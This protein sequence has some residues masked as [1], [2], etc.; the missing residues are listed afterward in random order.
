[1]AAADVIVLASARR[2]CM[3]YLSKAKWQERHFGRLVYNPTT[4]GL[5]LKESPLVSVESVVLSVD[6]APQVLVEG[7]DYRVDFIRSALV[8][9]APVT[10]CFH[11]L[12]IRYTAG[13]AP[14]PEDLQ[15][16]LDAA[17]QA[18]AAAATAAPAGVQS[19]DIPDVGGVRFADPSAY[20]SSLVPALAPFESVLN[21]YRDTSRYFPEASLRECVLVPEV[22]PLGVPQ[23]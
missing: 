7:V 10:V 23:P 18:Q 13:W 3:R 17:A 5:V 9:S 1:M 20:K 22:V 8:L 21:G 14:L 11:E 6:G 2:Y 19:V 16:V 12:T 15:A 4:V